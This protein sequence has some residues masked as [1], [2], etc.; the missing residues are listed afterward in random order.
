[1][2][3]E[4]YRQIESFGY[5]FCKAHSA[6]YAVESY[7]SLFKTYFGVEFM[8]AAINN[9]GGFYRPEIYIHEAKMSGGIIH[10][11]CINKSFCKLR[12]MLTFTWV[13]CC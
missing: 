6:S 11:P 8:V 2:S 10:N 12:S 5:S 13:L 1:L 9:G 4:V 3:E 7:Q